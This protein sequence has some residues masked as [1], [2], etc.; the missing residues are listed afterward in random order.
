MDHI[1]SRK[2]GGNSSPDNLALACVRCNAWKGSDIASFGLEPG[3]IVPLF[4]PRRSQWSDHFRPEDGMIVPLTGTGDA[5]I[6]LLRFNLHGRV[7]ERQI[8]IQCGRYN[9]IG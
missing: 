6:R 8:L 7:T 9:P 2:H 4:D 5:T 1:V 3:Q